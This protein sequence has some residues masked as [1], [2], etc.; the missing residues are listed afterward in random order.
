MAKTLSNLLLDNA[1]AMGL[2]EEPFLATAG[3]TTMIENTL[4][5]DLDPPPDAE[6]FDFFT[7]F[8]EY[9]NGGASAAPQGEYQ[10]VTAY[11]ETAFQFTTD[12]FSAAIGVD[13]RIVLMNNEVPL[14]QQILL[15]N[16][17]LVKYGRQ[18]LTDTSL[19]TVANQTEYNLPAGITKEN[20]YDV[21]IQGLTTDSNDN[22][23]HS[24]AFDVL[25]G[26][27]GSQ[28]VLVIDQYP[29]DYDLMLSYRD[30]H[31]RLSIFSSTISENLPY[32]QILAAFRFAVTDWYNNKNEG[33]NPY[34]V[35]ADRKAAGLLDVA[36]IE[37]PKRA[38]PIKN[39]LTY[40]NR[41][42]PDNDEFAPIPLP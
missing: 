19:T 10:R 16:Q 25:P 14:Q 6:D 17:V 13:D 22:R 29:Q 24:I 33:G 12:A 38:A 35:A 7:A 3:S 31:A 15:A 1:V 42:E 39:K 23:W 34:W 37:H 28:R 27:A 5:G 36:K 21:K 30:Y 2:T 9:D 8:V 18:D 32:S 20:L 26:A 4:L 11:D 41:N 40:L